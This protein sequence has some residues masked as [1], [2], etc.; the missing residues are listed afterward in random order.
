MIGAWVLIYGDL[1]KGVDGV[2]GL[3]ESEEAAEQYGEEHN[4]GHVERFAKPLELPKEDK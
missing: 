4:L 1:S 2:I 3:F